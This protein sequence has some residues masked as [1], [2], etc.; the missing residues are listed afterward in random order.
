MTLTRLNP[1][2]RF[3]QAVR[4]LLADQ[5]AQYML[6]D[7]GARGDGRAEFWSPLLR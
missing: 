3:P 4:S 2:T 5:R 1:W 7:I 6:M